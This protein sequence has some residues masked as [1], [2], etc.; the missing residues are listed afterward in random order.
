M[1]EQ[2]AR[3]RRVVVAA[4]KVAEALEKRQLLSLT[5]DQQ[6]INT[7][8][9]LSAAVRTDISVLEYQNPQ[10]A[11]AI[12]AILQPLGLTPIAPQDGSVVAYPAQSGKGLLARHHHPR[13]K[14]PP[15]H[16]KTHHHGKDGPTAPTV[17]GFAYSYDQPLPNQL[18]FTF[19][20]DVTSSDWTGSVSVID[21][22]NGTTL[23]T[24]ATHMP[25][26]NEL[27]FGLNNSTE[28]SDA[29]YA[30]ILHGSQLQ[31][32]TTGLSVVGNDGVAGDDSTFNFFFQES[33][34]NHDRNTNS[35]DLQIVLADLNHPGTFSGGDTNYDGYV[36]SADMQDVLFFL[37][38]SLPLLGT[39]GTPTAYVASSSSLDIEW[40][41]ASD[42]SVTEY[43]LYRNS[44]LVVSDVTDTGYL[45]TGLSTNT[46]YAYFVVGKDA[47]NDSSWQSTELLTA[48]A[49]ATPTLSLSGDPTVTEGDTYYL[50]GAFGDANNDEPTQWN[51]SWGDGTSATYSG[52]ADAVLDSNDAI[53]GPAGA[54]HTYSEGTYTITGTAYS[55]VGTL[56]ASAIVVDV[57]DATPTFS[58]LGDSTM[59]QGQPYSIT[60]SFTDFDTQNSWTVAWGDGTTASSGTGAIPA[61][62]THTY[63]SGAG[64]PYTIVANV[65]TND[66][67]YT[68]STTVD[69]AMPTLSVT[70]GA[71]VAVG[72]TYTLTDSFSDPAGQTPASWSIDWGDGSSPTTLSGDPTTATHVYS[73][74]LAN[75]GAYTVAAYAVDGDGAY[76][77][78]PDEVTK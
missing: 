65:V 20:E 14:P 3:S 9:H 59:V 40:T 41:T 74:T 66:G 45:D 76:Y 73:Q 58:V 64:A 67:T 69:E 23:V 47:N 28:L 5:P 51:I 15:R 72:S 43:D 57:T 48:I 52:F 1:S 8:D 34:F 63:S 6:F 44:S 60:A 49:P 68:N 11:T 36:N 38:K 24:S 10:Y 77:A 13:P 17:T 2:G 78:T 56:A 31:G 42:P 70:G 46:T 33:D 21:L 29:N 75:S 18:T 27:V 12:D 26:Y 32:A 22:S 50:G 16:P 30:A 4:A 61:G 19:S 53:G 7:W 54:F 37:N 35:A 62:L 71:S 55:D 25:A 39:P